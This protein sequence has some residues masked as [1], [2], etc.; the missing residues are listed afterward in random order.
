[1]IL[2]LIIRK[3]NSFFSGIRTVATL[4][5][6]L[7]FVLSMIK[8][9]CNRAHTEDLVERITGL[10]IQ[11]DILRDSIDYREKQIKNLRDS[12]D[13]AAD[14]LI[15]LVHENKKLK[16]KISV[17]EKEKRDVRANAEKMSSDSS[18]AFLNNEA[19]PFDGEKK[20]LFN[21]PQIK[22][23]HLTYLDNIAC[24]GILKETNSLVDNLNDQLSLKDSQIE[25]LESSLI[26]HSEN[27]MAYSRIVDN[28]D[29]EVTLYQKELKEEKKKTLFWKIA[30]GIGIGVG[31]LIAL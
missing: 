21:E 29:E 2:S 17:L 23:I 14:T 18:Y 19:Y 12:I 25:Q 27:I 4:F 10:N 9:G 5:L 30:G 16:S 22:E 7:L 6:V 1:M 11:N 24:Q 13:R 20:Y 8:H 15:V 26:L 28:K 3:C 31:I